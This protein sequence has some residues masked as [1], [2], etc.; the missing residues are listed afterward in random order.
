MR[1]NALPAEYAWRPKSGRGR[2]P[3]RV[4]H[5]DSVAAGRDASKR[6]LQAGGHRGLG[7]V[8]DVGELTENVSEYANVSKILGNARV[9]P[10]AGESNQ[11]VWGEHALC[12]GTGR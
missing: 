11:A 10:Y 4:G 8:G 1:R 7:V 3:R 2:R 5:E 9:D 6:A 12:G